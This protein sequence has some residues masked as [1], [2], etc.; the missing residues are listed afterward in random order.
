MTV[1]LSD[2]AKAALINA[3]TS[4][5]G[6]LLPQHTPGPVVTELRNAGLIGA[7]GGLT[8][9]GGVER[10]RAITQALDAAL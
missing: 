2:T 7:Y 6:A 1:K 8:R 9:T 5:Q 10:D 3:S 4:R